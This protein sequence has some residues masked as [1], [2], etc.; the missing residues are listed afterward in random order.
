MSTDDGNGN[1]NAQGSEGSHFGIDSR[2][3]RCIFS[4]LLIWKNIANNIKKRKKRIVQKSYTDMKN[5]ITHFHMLATVAE[6]K[7]WRFLILWAV[8]FATFQMR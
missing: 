1:Q 2:I 3:P 8:M 4:P 6:N 5:N 7:D